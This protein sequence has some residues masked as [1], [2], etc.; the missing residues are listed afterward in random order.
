MLF[1]S[2][3]AFVS[4]LTMMKILHG[5]HTHAHSHNVSHSHSKGHSHSEND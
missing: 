1:T 2:I 4:N 5:S 3:F